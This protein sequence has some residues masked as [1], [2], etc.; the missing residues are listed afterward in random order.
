MIFK[1]SPSQAVAP[2]QAGMF[3]LIDAR[4]CYLKT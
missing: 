3:I 4:M 1:T 2:E